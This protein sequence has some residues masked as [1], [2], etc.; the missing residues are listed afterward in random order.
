MEIV[1]FKTLASTQKYLIEQLHRGKLQAPVA[2]ITSEQHNG[3]G[4]RDNEW[5]GGEGNFFASLAIRLDELP[6]DLPLSSASIYFSFIMKKTLVSL[7][8]NIWLKWPNDFY[9]NGDKV[10]GTI[11]KKINNILVCGIGIN[12]KNSQNGYRALQS[13]ISPES[14]LEN[15]LLALQK[16]P[17][18]KQIFSEYEVEFELSR[19]FSVHIENYQKSLADACLQPDGSLIIEEERVYSL[20]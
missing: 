15:Y 14:L 8:E 17:K 4:S 18:W 11:T 7:G 1:S 12:L 9:K 20:R 3:V 19:K 16:F 6:E 13:D 10:G 5:S 2:V